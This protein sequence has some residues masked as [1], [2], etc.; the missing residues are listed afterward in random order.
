MIFKLVQLLLPKNP[1]IVFIRVDCPINKS[2][3][4]SFFPIAQLPIIYPYKT[5]FAWNSQPVIV[6]MASN[7]FK[8]IVQINISCICH[9]TFYM[10]SVVSVIMEQSVSNPVGKP[11]RFYNL[12][13]LIAYPD[14]I[15]SMPMHRAF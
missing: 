10:D 5:I 7:C 4:L 8:K 9:N 13:L 14:F 12:Y 3:Q 11:L 15:V 1:S 6:Q 2:L